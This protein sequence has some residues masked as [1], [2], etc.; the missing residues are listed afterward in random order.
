[1]EFRTPPLLPPSIVFS[2][3]FCKTLKKNHNALVTFT[4]KHW[5]MEE[6]T[7]IWLTFLRQT[8]P[9]KV[10]GIFYDYSPSHTNYKLEWV[11][12]QNE[13]NTNGTRIILDYIDP[14]LTSIYQPCDVV[15]NNTLKKKGR[16]LSRLNT[17]FELTTW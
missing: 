5:Q 17:F 7:M 9:D 16:I 14:C 8:F 11:E 10:I 15:I 6:T 2:D 12:L 3:G 13:V 4:K 1:M